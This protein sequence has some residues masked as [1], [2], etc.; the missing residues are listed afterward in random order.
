ML[1]AHQEVELQKICICNIHVHMHVYILILKD[2]SEDHENLQPSQC[3]PTCG[4]NQKQASWNAAPFLSDLN[5]TDTK[6]EVGEQRTAL[7]LRFVGMEKMSQD[8]P[9]V[10]V[11]SCLALPM[12]AF[13]LQQWLQLLIHPKCGFFMLLR[14]ESSPVNLC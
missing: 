3:Q 5:P 14:T 1:T 11:C 2:F 13:C 9:R 8:T 4:Y 10:P 7:L 12:A 6:K